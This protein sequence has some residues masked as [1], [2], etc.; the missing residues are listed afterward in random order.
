MSSNLVCKR[1]NSRISV[2][3]VSV[4]NTPTNFC[5]KCRSFLFQEKKSVGRPSIGKTKKISLT[6]PE[7]DWLKLDSLANGNRSQFI[8]KTIVKALI[9]E[10]KK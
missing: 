3:I 6:L 10:E 9:D 2:E 8:R 4:N 7:E 1:C 5:K